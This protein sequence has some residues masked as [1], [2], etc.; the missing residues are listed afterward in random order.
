MV[1]HS[2][3]FRPKL[4]GITA[5]GLRGHTT[6]L[7]MTHRT[8]KPQ[9]TISHRSGSSIYGS[10]HHHRRSGERHPRPVVKQVLEKDFDSEAVIWDTSDLT[11]HDFLTFRPE[12]GDGFLGLSLAGRV[13]SHD[14]IHSIWWR[15]PNGFNLSKD[16]YGEK[17]ARFCTNEYSALL[18]GALASLPC[19]MVNTPQKET[20]ANRKPFQLKM[21]QSVGLPIPN[22]LISNDPE[23]VRSFWEANQNDCIY[24]SLTPTPDQFRETRRLRREDL[25]DLGQLR[26]API[27]VQEQSRARTCASTCLGTRSLPP[28]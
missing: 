11:G 27:I 19:P 26:Y 1:E 18:D 6:G 5:A 25:N 3:T 2:L 7:N 8:I 15:R 10:H 4:Y 21:A 9:T 24:K 23:Q 13:L 14:D 16:V 28:Q 12:A 20:L 17:V 22:T